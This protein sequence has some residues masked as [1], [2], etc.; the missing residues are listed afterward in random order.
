MERARH[1]NPTTTWLRLAPHLRFEG[2]LRLVGNYA[3][4]RPQDWLRP[5][6]GREARRSGVIRH[7]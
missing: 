3:Q 6:F 1:Y 2:F 7:R 4:S 5:P